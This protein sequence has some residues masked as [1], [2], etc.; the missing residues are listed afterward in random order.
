MLTLRIGIEEDHDTVTHCSQTMLQ[1]ARFT[2]VLLLQ[3][4]NAWIEM[5]RAL[6]FG[7]GLIMRTVVNDNDFDFAFVVTGKKRA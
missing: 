7:G 2:A 5:R 6:N 4:T 1:C 3:Q